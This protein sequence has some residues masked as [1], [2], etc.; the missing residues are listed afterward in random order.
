MSMLS[1]PKEYQ[2]SQIGTSH[3]SQVDQAIQDT[4]IQ[5]APR[6]IFDGKASNDGTFPSSNSLIE[7]AMALA[8]TDLLTQVT[9]RPTVQDS[10]AMM[11]AVESYKSELLNQLSKPKNWPESLGLDPDLHPS[12]LSLFDI[13]GAARCET[14]DHPYP[15][16]MVLSLWPRVTICDEEPATLVHHTI[17]HP[18]GC[19]PMCG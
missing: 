12:L 19:F 13:T 7:K 10:A 9:R 14:V 17:M 18:R 15:V 4:V 2:I 5:T 3:A 8:T 1:M 11:A 16:S 6:Q